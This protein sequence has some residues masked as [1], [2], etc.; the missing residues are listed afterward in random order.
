MPWAA[1]YPAIARTNEQ[2]VLE[3]LPTVLEGIAFQSL[4]RTYAALRA[5]LGELQTVTAAQMGSRNPRMTSA[6]TRCDRD[7]AAPPQA[8]CSARTIWHHLG[9]RET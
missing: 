4:R 8:A 6:S 7:E 9:T 2:L 3:H 1:R 5:G